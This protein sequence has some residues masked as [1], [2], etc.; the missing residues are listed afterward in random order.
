MRDSADS[1]LPKRARFSARCFGL[2]K[3]G[4]GGGPKGLRET[5]AKEYVKL[6]GHFTASDAVKQELLLLLKARLLAHDPPCDSELVADLPV[7]ATCRSGDD[8][9]GCRQ[10]IARPGGRSNALQP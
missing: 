3:G 6:A 1:S 2:G 5:L 4:R 8:A 9:C 7:T 10:S